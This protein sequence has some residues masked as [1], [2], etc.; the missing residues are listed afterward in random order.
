MDQKQDIKFCDLHCDTAMDL[1]NGALLKN[2]STEVNIPFMKAGNVALQLFACYLPPSIH[3]HLRASVVLKVLDKLVEEIA[4]N[5]EAIVLCKDYRMVNQVFQE[6][7][8]GAIL[9][10]ENGMAIENDLKNLELFFSRGVRC[11]TIVHA[12][13]HEWAISSN[14]KAPKFDG[15]SDFGKR[16]ISAM[17][18]MGMIVDLSHAHD[19]TVKKVLKISR[20]PVIAT[21][22][23]VH[24]LC[25]VPRNLQDELIKGIADTGGMIGINFYPGF[26]DATYANT[27]TNRAGELFAELSKMERASGGDVQ[28]I[29]SLFADFRLKIKPMMADTRVPVDRIIDHV[30]YIINLVGDDFVGFGSDFDGIPDSPEGIDN[31]RDF[32]LIKQKLFDKGYSVNTIEKI[33]SKNF[34][35]VLQSNPS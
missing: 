31:C 28:K 26:L 6:Q 11:L 20:K 10:I 1:L 23:C 27:I 4:N 14:D 8:I 5:S 9:T 7:K 13:S 25:P 33:A 18:E 22:S 30:D 29:T 16:V 19:C 12:E 35:R 24:A 15:L 21:H 3:R 34:L 2:H 32:N 17:N